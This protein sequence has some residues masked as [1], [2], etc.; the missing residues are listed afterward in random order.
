MARHKFV[1][2]DPHYSQ[3]SM[4]AFAG[5]TGGPLRPWGR[6][7]AEG[8]E[9]SLEEKT[10]RAA[11]MDEA[12]VERWNAVVPATGA[13]VYMLGD[14]VMKAVHLPILDRLNGKKKLIFGNHDILGYKK[15]APYFYDMAAYRI[16]DGIVMSHIPI[17][18]ESL[19]ER[20]SA[21]VH[22]HLHDGRVMMNIPGE[23]GKFDLP[24]EIPEVEVIHP[25]YL[26]VSVEHTDYAP[27]SF[28]EMFDRIARQKEAADAT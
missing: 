23:G 2:A 11:A 15:Y 24:W 16:G 13:T 18:E 3:G 27:L 22:G 12:M 10:E 7:C 25:R 21:N 8:E 6:V 4:C 17:H 5:L 19:K 9:M 20:W 28:D 1:I 26:C 14:I